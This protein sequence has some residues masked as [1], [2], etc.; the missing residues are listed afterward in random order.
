MLQSGLLLC[1]LF[2][3]QPTA[4]GFLARAFFIGF[5][6]YVLLL[7]LVVGHENAEK[8]WSVVILIVV[9]NVFI[10]VVEVVEVIVVVG[11]VVVGDLSWMA[12]V[13]VGRAEV[14]F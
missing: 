3:L 7:G 4:L 11:I 12:G 5:V 10:E 6:C 14:A 1:L 9:A 8:E 13:D 2:R